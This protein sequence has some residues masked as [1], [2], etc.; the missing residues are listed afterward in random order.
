VQNFIRH[1]QRRH[2]SSSLATQ[3]L[4]ASWRGYVVRQQLRRR[5]TASEEG[6]TT[7]VASALARCTPICAVVRLLLARKLGAKATQ[8]TADDSQIDMRSLEFVQSEHVTIQRKNIIGLGSLQYNMKVGADVVIEIQRRVEP[9]PIDLDATDANPPMDAVLETVYCHR[10]V[11]ATVS[12]FCAT[13]FYGRMDDLLVH[14][15]LP[16]VHLRWAG[17]CYCAY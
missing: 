10:A 17:K 16:Y 3:K 7:S 5:C 9:L 11:L 13:R 2:V 1:W 8:D 12:S 15:Q 6:E 4:Q 14:V